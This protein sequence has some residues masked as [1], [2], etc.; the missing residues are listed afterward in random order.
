[1]RIA[2]SLPRST[3]AVGEDVV[4]ALTVENDGAAPL[5]IPDPFH[6]YNWEPKYTITGPAHPGGSTFS[7]RS[8]ARRD[9]RP[10]PTDADPVLTTLA[11][12]AKIEGELPL[13]VWTRLDVPGDYELVAH[14][15]WAGQSAKSGPARF[16]LEPLGIVSA[17]MG[18]DV[19]FDGTRDVWVTWIRRSVTTS[20]MGDAVFLELRPDLG[21]T[22]RIT[23]EPVRPVG[24]TAREALCPWTAYDRKEKL[25][26]W[27]L[28][29]ESG[30]LVALLAGEPQPRTASVGAA[31]VP[32]RPALMT[33]DGALDLF[34][35]D[36]TTQEPLHVRFE[37]A[38]PAPAITRARPLSGNVV[39]G[40][41]VVPRSAGGDRDA[42]VV[43]V[44]A[45][46]VA[47]H[48][49]RLSGGALAVLGTVR[50]AGVRI[51]PASVPAAWIDDEGVLTAVL[52]A[53]DEREPE[54]IVRADARFG[55]GATPESSLSRVGHLPRPPRSARAVYCATPGPTP[56]RVDWA[57]LLDDGSAVSSQST[58]AQS[59]GAAALVPL[60]MVAL[61]RTT[62]VLVASDTAGPLLVPLHAGA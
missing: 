42:V 21:E 36:S 10:N 6:A 3:Y 5:E 14:L 49:L 38:S 15:E 19:G 33:D 59:L 26:F 23:M 24:S 53:C 7:F 50:F 31:F 57:V 28:W 25:A 60:E 35:F 29:R 46:G 16:S 40:A 44:E 18:V 39:G 32:L 9:P 8:A 37:S 20:E 54:T 34:G 22:K 56:P 12:G 61:S 62:Y 48:H 47:M 58:S 4:A 30:D 43:C 13:H 17:S 1:M 41:A 27:R 51:L 52:I 45:G 2:L 11:P 55:V